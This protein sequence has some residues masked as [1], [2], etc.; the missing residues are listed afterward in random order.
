MKKTFKVQGIYAS[1]MVLQRN[2][3]NCIYG[4]AKEL[5]EISMEFRDITYITKATQEG[6]WKIEFC[7]GNAGGA[8]TMTVKCESEKIEFTDVFVGEVWVLSGQ[9]NAQ[10]P[11]ER[12]KFSYPEEFA[13]PE[14]SKIRMITIPVKWFFK[15]EQDSVENPQWVCANPKNIG[16][17]SG[18][19]Y[20]FAKKLSEELRVHVGI[21]NASQ[22]GSPISAWMSKQALFEMGDKT[23]YLKKLEYFENDD[24]VAAMQKDIAENQDKWNRELFGLSKMPDFEDDDGWETVNIP[25]I[26]KNFDSAGLVWI[27]KTI[28]L[29]SKQIKNFKSHKTWLWFG[30]IVD[31]DKFYIN[32]IKIGETSYCYPPRRYEVPPEILKEGKNIISAHVQLNNHN[33]R[34]RFYEEKP[35]CLFTENVFVQPTA[36]RNIEN[37]EQTLLPLDSEKIDLTGEWKIKADV[38]IRDC[39]EVTFFEWQPTAL[40][41]AMLSPCFKS[42]VSGVLWYQ[43]ESDA[44]RSEEYKSMLKKMIDL[45]RHKF[46]YSAKELPFVIMQ[47]P[48]WS[49]GNDED[50]A[51]LDRGWAKMRQAQSDAVDLAEHAGLAVTID[52]GEWNDLHPEKKLTCGTRAAL[53]ALRVAYGRSYISASPKVCSCT[54]KRLKCI[55]RFDCGN[56]ILKACKVDGKIADLNTESKDKKVYG[57]SLLYS[58]KGNDFIIET[59]GK[60]KTDDTVEVSIPICCK[61]LKELRYLWANSPAPINLYSSDLLPAAPFRVIKG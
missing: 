16:T 35:Y 3:I 58:K 39:P 22:G 61:N 34:I 30:A 50:V 7:P 56:S 28:E 9:S 40:Y 13:F 14:N 26:V 55:V 53:E 48:N 2:K 29:D 59:T 33:S 45:W 60:L 47:L 11:M 51:S 1:G 42:T 36:T 8:F 4:T 10:L 17:M 37:H 57:F 31:A 12:M 21:I 15:G 43:G 6:D 32:G 24:N 54:F 52:A 25:G 5:S 27:K 41:N 38:K 44:E 19:G 18:T 46:V 49:D 20:F 23:K